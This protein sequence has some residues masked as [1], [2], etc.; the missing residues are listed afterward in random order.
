MN[1]GIISGSITI[2]AGYNAS[3]TGPVGLADGV[4]ITI[5]TG[6]EFVIF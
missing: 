2:P 5:P 6:S 4:I 1:P 3:M